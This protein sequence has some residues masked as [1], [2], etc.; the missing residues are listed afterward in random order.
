MSSIN[1]KVNME[2]KPMKNVQQLLGIGLILFLVALLFFRD[3]MGISVNKYIFCVLIIPY[4]IM[5]DI[6]NSII[7][8]SFCMPLYVGLPG[9]YVTV[10]FLLR[11]IFDLC[12]NPVI[13][14]GPQLLC[15][16]FLAVFM[17]IQNLALGFY[18]VYNMMCI[19]DLIIVFFLIFRTD[20]SYIPCAITAYVAGVSFVGIVMLVS[21]LQVVPFS[22]L[23]AAGSRLGDFTYFKGMCVNIDPNF[24]GMHAVTATACA[25]ALFEKHILRKLQSLLSLIFVI[26]SD[27][28]ALIGLSR[29]FI[30]CLALWIIFVLLFS[31]KVK[32]K[33]KIILIS[34]ITVAATFYFFPDVINSLI[35]RFNGDDM[36]TGNGRLELLKLYGEQWNSTLVTLLFGIGLFVSEAHCMPAQFLFGIGIIGSIPLFYLGISYFK[37]S[38][39]GCKYKEVK[40]AVIPAVV[41]QISAAMLPAARSLSMMIP[42]VL[43]FLVI[44]SVCCNELSKNNHKEQSINEKA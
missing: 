11:L 28:I 16:L 6:K 15:T 8:W 5:A 29:G 12:R 3:A 20:R 30:V 18:D 32:Y 14:K 41:I 42:V 38:F 4:I 26:V 43:S 21:T 19:C 33:G 17:L 36:S 35:D 34:A 9:N 22:D 10:F 25:W 23:L 1:S 27:I 37:Y 24:Y 40:T 31:N 13:V 2:F 7:L 44:Q 39:L